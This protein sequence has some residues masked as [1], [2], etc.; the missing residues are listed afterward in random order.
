MSSQ[1]TDILAYMNDGSIQVPFFEKVTLANNQ[2]D[3]YWIAAVDI[4]GDGRLDIVTSGLA[5]G[6][7]VWYE[8]PT[9]KKRVIADF[10]LPV[11]IDPGD[12]AGRGRNDL[13]ILH[14]YGNCMFWCRPEDGKVS[15]LE[16]RWLRQ[17]LVIFLPRASLFQ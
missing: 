13:V 5:V 1:K 6:K 10:P 17:R 7:V 11:A 2:D 8:N 16:N 14:N 9:W 3:G 12:I 15:W 4:N